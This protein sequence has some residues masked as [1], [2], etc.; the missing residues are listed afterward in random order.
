MI[1]TESAQ[2]IAH[3][4]LTEEIFSLLLEAPKIATQ[5]KP[6]QFVMIRIS[7][8]YSFMLRRPFAIADCTQNN[9][10][11]IYRVVGKGTKELSKRKP[12]ENLDILGPLGRSIP[13]LK[14]KKIALCAGGIGIAPLKLVASKLA[15]TNELYLYYGAKTKKELLFLNE[16]KALCGKLI[17]ATEDG[18]WGKKGLI[19]NFLD[20][21]FFKEQKIEVLFAAGPLK[22]LKNLKIKLKDFPQL[23]PYVFLESRMGCGCGLCYCCGVKTIN[24]EY[25]RICTDGPVFNLHQVELT[26]LEL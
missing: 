23:I 17:L 6:G 22:M 15:Q 4:Q 16:L 25:L 1:V 2:I 24:G 14:N 13:N 9:I 20:V 10:R 21:A 26:S 11:I 18:S 3:H 5:V 19:V 7:D 12:K 8:N